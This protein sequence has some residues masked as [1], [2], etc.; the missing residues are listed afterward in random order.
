MLDSQS[1][2]FKKKNYEI[3]K[4]TSIYKFLKTNSLIKKTYNLSYQ[5]KNNKLKKDSCLGKKIKQSNNT[6]I[7]KTIPRI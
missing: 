5:Q 3:V 7:N 1:N 6:R 2:S 4:L